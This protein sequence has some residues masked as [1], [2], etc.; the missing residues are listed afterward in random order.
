MAYTDSYKLATYVV[1][2]DGHGKILQLKKSDYGKQWGIP[3]GGVD[4]GETV[5][6]GRTLLGGDEEE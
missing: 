1:I 6:A 5:I 3:G 2:F 4:P